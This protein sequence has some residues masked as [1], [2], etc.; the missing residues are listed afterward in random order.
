MWITI[1]RALGEGEVFEIVGTHLCYRDKFET[2]VGQKRK[3][4]KKK[5][6][7]SFVNAKNAIIGE[8]NV[9]TGDN[10]IAQELQGPTR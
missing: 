9:S 1:R 5:T 7:V 3:K 4:K 6:K 8:L 10:K 2:E